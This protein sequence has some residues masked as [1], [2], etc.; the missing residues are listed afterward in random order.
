[1]CKCAS[2]HLVGPQAECVCAV[3]ESA[4]ESEEI[5]IDPANGEEAILGGERGQ[6]GREKEIEKEKEREREREGGENSD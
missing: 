5:E 2:T 4:V 1:M 6:L 3:A